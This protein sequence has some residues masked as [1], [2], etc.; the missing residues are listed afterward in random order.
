MCGEDQIIFLYKKLNSNLKQPIN[1]TMEL[2]NE[3]VICFEA[4]KLKYML[5]GCMHAICLACARQC[6]DN[7]NIN[8]ITVEGRFHVFT[9]D[10]YQPMSCPLCRAV[11]KKMTLEEFEQYYPDMYDEWFQLEL[12]CD[13][14]GCS[15]YET[16]EDVPK[17]RKNSYSKTNQSVPKPMKWKRKAIGQKGRRKI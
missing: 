15:Y 9:E 5:T 10:I 14:D 7:A 6:K 4:M 13:L 12:N 1:K 3:C 17:K 2:L 16:Y 8:S 11:E